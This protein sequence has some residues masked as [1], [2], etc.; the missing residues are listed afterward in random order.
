MRNVIV[1]GGS[2]GVGLA[3]ARRL[4][5][6]GYCVITLARNASDPLAD[7]IREAEDD[8]LGAIHFRV[9]DLAEIDAIPDLVRTLRKDFGPLYGLVNN[10]AVGTAGVLANMH[11]AQI[12]RV[13]RL[14]TLSPIVLSKYAVRSMMAE[15]VGRIVNVAS[16]VAFSGGSGLSVYGATK[17]SMI[18]FT[19]SLAREVGRLGI[20]VNAVAP[21]F[22]AT[23]MTESLTQDQREQ[24]A[25]RSALQRLVDPEDVAHS[26]EFLMSEKSRNITGTVLTVDAGNTA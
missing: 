3:I 15:G 16:I 20:N 25:R 22:M 8:H 6:S 7:A 14:N 24:V 26:V 17:A 10:A 23:D 18:G 4:A 21:G 1:T 9:F 11:N 19:R 13:V 5:Q 2:R 12:E